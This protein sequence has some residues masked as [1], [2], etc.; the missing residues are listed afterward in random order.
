[1]NRKNYMSCLWVMSGIRD[2]TKG[3]IVVGDV[4]YPCALGKGALTY[5][6][7]EGDGAT[8]IAAMAILGGVYRGDRSLYPANGIGLTR[9]KRTDGWCD[10]PTDGRYNRPVRLPI[11][12]SHE[13]MMRSDRLYDVVLVLDW[14]ITERARGRGSAIFLHVAHADYR[15]TEGCVAVSPETM[16]RLLPILRRGT[17]VRIRGS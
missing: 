11:V 10:D 4:R 15:P 17:M 6:K 9:I 2:K 8:P 5:S 1:M 13:K 7:R 14:N 16:R 12:K 3:W